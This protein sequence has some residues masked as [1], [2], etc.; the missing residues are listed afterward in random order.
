MSTTATAAHRKL[1]QREAIDAA[2]S[3][4]QLT[5]ERVE[6]L[7]RTVK[8]LWHFVYDPTL[9]Q[10]IPDQLCRIRTTISEHREQVERRARE[11][12]LDLA[13]TQQQ[14][15]TLDA[16]T[17]QQ[18]VRAF[19]YLNGILSRGFWGRLKWLVTGK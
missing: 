10:N 14:A 6:K 3:N 11:M 19:K 2:L 7:E 9:D 12:V 8:D 5:R 16:E 17:H 1:T 18:H 13:K 15:W 4:E